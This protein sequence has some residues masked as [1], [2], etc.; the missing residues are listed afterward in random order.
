MCLKLH[1]AYE[2]RLLI[3]RSSAIRY[4]KHANVIIIS[5]GIVLDFYLGLSHKD[6]KNC[7]NLWERSAEG[8]VRVKPKTLEV[9]RMH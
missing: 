1:S 7:Y 9:E 2:P 3:K 8:V 4:F 6:Y 5:K